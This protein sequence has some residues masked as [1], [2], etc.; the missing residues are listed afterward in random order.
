MAVQQLLKNPSQ[1]PVPQADPKIKC[2]FCYQNKYG[3][4]CATCEAAVRAVHLIVPGTFGETAQLH[5]TS[6]PAALAHQTNQGARTAT[7]P[8]LW[9]FSQTKQP[10]TTMH[11]AIML[12]NKYLGYFQ[13]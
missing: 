7:C 10:L 2:T 11:V 6:R 5:A 13:R 12:S 8:D 4:I 9:G 1:E 3:W